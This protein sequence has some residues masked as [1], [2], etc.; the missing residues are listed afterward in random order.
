MWQRLAAIWA[1]VWRR[2]EIGL[3]PVLRVAR[4]AKG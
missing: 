4:F 1:F 2:V 3:P